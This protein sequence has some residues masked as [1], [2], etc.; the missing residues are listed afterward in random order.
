MYSIPRQQRNFIRKLLVAL[1]LALIFCPFAPLLAKAHQLLPFH[2]EYD[3]SDPPA[4]ARLPSGHPPTRVQVWFTEQ[5]DPNFSKLAVFNQARHE[6]DLGDSHVAPNDPSSLVISLHPRLTDGAYTVVFQ[7]VSAEDG[8][9]VTSAFSFVVGGGLLPTNTSTLL[10][11]IQ[12]ADTNLNI[13]SVMIRWVNYLGLAGLVGGLAF[14][15]LVWRPSVVLLTHQMGVSLDDASTQLESR[16]WLFCLWC[17]LIL[18]LE[19]FCFLIYQAS[20]ASASP[21][22]QLFSNGAL[23]TVLL[24]S[25]L[26]ALWL[27]RL[28]LLVFSSILW[29][30]LY[31]SPI[32]KAHKN[33]LLWFILLAG[34]GMMCTN[35][36]SSHAAANRVAWL[37]IPV[38]LLHLV[39]TGFWIGGLFCLVLVLPVALRTLIPGTGDRTRVLAVIIPRFTVVAMISVVLL[40]VTGMVQALIQLNVLNAFF[41]GSYGQVL[42]AFLG[43]AYGQAL[44]IK[45][46]LFAVL[47]SFGAFSAFRISPKM[48]RFAKRSN[49]QDGAG[50]FAAGRLQRTF[51][52]AV[53]IE[54]VISVCLLLVVGG[55]TS[56]SPPPPSPSSVTSGPLLLQG[57]IADLTYHLA[58]NPGKIGPNTFEVALTEKDGQP[59]Q[60][61][62]DVEAYFVMEDMDMGIEVLDFTPA[63]NTPGYYGATAS[64]LSMAGRWQIDLI[65]RRAGFDDAKVAIHCTI[66]S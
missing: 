57:Q 40:A 2:A 8:H 56:L 43:S 60:H 46:V 26:G 62:N 54:A 30:L 6:V 36:L 50:S 51:K 63:R 21:L 25:H 18:F 28:G 53:T 66:S 47:I 37:L 59:A 1:S 15:L 19:W 17:F 20:T 52:R 24:H 29:F 14:L 33:N 58:I 38:D 41:S 27:V 64:I 34:V 61:I 9:E 32:E 12:V 4:N 10:R 44:A 35:S 13:W 65:V 22:W 39:S 49:E 23:A 5:V 3:H 42:S 45:S 11:N 55:L 7:T 31:R 48:R 16:T